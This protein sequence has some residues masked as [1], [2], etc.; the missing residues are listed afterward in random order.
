[1]KKFTFLWII[2]LTPF[3]FQTSYAKEFEG[4][5]TYEITCW[6]QDKSVKLSDLKKAFGKQHT[7]YYKNGAHKWISDKTN[8]R[9]ELYNPDVDPNYIYSTY[10]DSDTV[11]ATNVEI[12]R[13]T[14]TK[15]VELDNQ[16]VANK[17]CAG[18]TFHVQNAKGRVFLRRT[19]YCPTSGLEF[20]EGRYENYKANGQNF[21]IAH[22]GSVP[23]KII[24]EWPGRQYAIIYE[25]VKIEEV[26][27]EDSFFQ[28]EKNVPVKYEDE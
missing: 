1:M 21:L 27:L 7:F 3:L 9:S 26:P 6:R 25:A 28:L 10:A 22:C 2:L 19:W 18:Y 24:L 15:V 23:L 11:F 20:E 8:F 5:V 4:I 14:V 17:I 12:Q 13:D 16:V